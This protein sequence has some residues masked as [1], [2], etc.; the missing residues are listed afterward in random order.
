MLPQDYQ[1][2]DQDRAYDKSKRLPS[3]QSSSSSS[4][5]TAPGSDQQDIHNQQQQQLDNSKRQSLSWRPSGIAFIPPPTTQSRS[6]ETSVVKC[7]VLLCKRSLRSQKADHPTQYEA[8]RMVEDWRQMQVEL[9]HQSLSLYSFPASIFPLIWPDRWLEHELKIP[10][11]TRFGL[12]SPLDYTFFVCYQTPSGTIDTFSF[13]A[14]S[15]TVCREWYMALYRVLPDQVKPVCSPWCEVHI[16]LLELRV[17][18]P[19]WNE[20]GEIRYDITL[21]SVHNAVISVLQQD[22]HWKKLIDSG[23][24]NNH[25]LGMCWSRGN[26]TE[27]VYWNQSLTDAQERIDLVISPQH[28]EQ[29]HRLELRHV[30]HAPS[31]IWL[32]DDARLEEPLPIEGYMTR[33]TTFTGKPLSNALGRLVRKS[34]YFASFDQYLFIIAHDAKIPPIES[35]CH[36]RETAEC[37]FISSIRQDQLDIQEHHRRLQL[38]TAAAHVIDL[39]EVSYVR[40]VFDDDSSMP[41]TS[42]YA[43]IIQRE[44]SHR[45]QICIEIVMVNGMILKFKPESSELC[46]TWVS[47]LTKLS[48]YWRARK[49]AERDIHASQDFGQLLDDEYRLVMTGEEKSKEFHRRPEVDTR[50]W[51][52][53]PFE[54]CRDIVKAG[55][56]YFQPRSRGTFSQKMFMLTANG[57]IVYYNMFEREPLSCQP[58]KTA[59][60][61]RKGQLDINDCYVYSSPFEVESPCRIYSDGAISADSSEECLFSLW[62]PERRRVFSP[63]RQRIT[64]YKNNKHFLQEKGETWQFLARNRHEKEEWVSAINVVIERLLR[65]QE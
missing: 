61:E 21:Q 14:L 43:S 62:K 55:I 65:G 57:W 25:Q 45:N 40:R 49:E 63:K 51:N 26:R 35:T 44:E 19:L 20:D 28:I 53:C 59:V 30:D 50:I 7:D 6:T 64:V 54:G 22:E 15:I 13:R 36:V 48:L 34:H 24:K 41:T 10:R 27:W 23:F 42:D 39:T 18:L 5:N 58:M 33:L 31:N 11:I 46:D 37:V 38:I 9:T 12:L 60:H 56:M 32:E 2:D 52:I 3:I 17:K 1:L 8:S 29:T 47:Y 4:A 16:P